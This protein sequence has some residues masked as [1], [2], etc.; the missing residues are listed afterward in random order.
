M[1]PTF[2]WATRSHMSLPAFREAFD[3]LE[4]AQSRFFPVNDRIEGPDYIWPLTPLHEWSRRVEYPFVARELNCKPGMRVLDAGSGVTFFPVYLLERC[5]MRVEC[6]DN[7]P[8]YADRMSQACKL[9]GIEP[10]V[11][12]HV[13]DLEGRLPFPDKTFDA[14]VCI[15]VLEHL[16][17]EARLK[18]VRELWRIVADGGHFI[19]TV[20]VSLDNDE[21]AG[22][23]VSRVREFAASLEAALNVKLPRPTLPPPGDLLTSRKPGYGLFPIRVGDKVVRGGPRSWYY[24]LPRRW[25]YRLRGWPQH[26]ARGLACLLFSATKKGVDR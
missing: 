5:K 12:F 8:S 18:T 16:S 4:T 22:I 1:P 23:P 15:S 17:A 21:T 19:M 11:P 26:R 13:A 7:E 3:A 14:V 20:D 6:L 9:L 2:E 25:Y 24:R 10:P